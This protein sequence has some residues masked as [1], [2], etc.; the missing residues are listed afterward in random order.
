MAPPKR[1]DPLERESDVNFILRLRLMRI[2]VGEILER[3]NRK[4]V[5]VAYEAARAEGWPEEQA[6]EFAADVRVSHQTLNADCRR[7][8]K[9]LQKEN[10]ALGR[11]LAEQRLAELEVEKM[12]LLLAEQRAWEELDRSGSPG[13][14]TGIRKSPEVA[15]LVP[16]VRA[17]DPRW[18][19]RI[20]SILWKRVL[21]SDKIYEQR[22][23][24]G[25]DAPLEQVKLAQGGAKDAKDKLLAY[26]VGL[27]YSLDAR[28][29]GLDAA[30]LRQ[31][32]QTVSAFL[33]QGQLPGEDGRA[34]GKLTIEIVGLEVTDGRGESG[35]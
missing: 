23:L 33:E 9:Q 28:A 35:S 11:E 17:A 27:L 16:V 34:G 5:E 7:V 1:S 21:L 15:M 6:R 13:L 22:A 14:R 31:R 26:E 19:E 25:L 8:K 20:E 18:M 10:R 12:T 2:P 24:L 4:R 29:A 3:L 32:Y 30:T